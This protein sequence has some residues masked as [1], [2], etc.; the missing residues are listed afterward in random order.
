MQSSKLR[1]ANQTIQILPIPATIWYQLPQSHQQQ[2][3]H[4]VAQLI[5]RARAATKDKEPH[6]E[7]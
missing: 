5:Q 6:H 7:R 2:L 1:A 4:L 3:A